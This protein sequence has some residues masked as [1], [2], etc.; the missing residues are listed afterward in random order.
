MDEEASQCP[1]SMSQ[2]TVGQTPI[3][4]RQRDVDDPLLKR[5][6]PRLQAGIGASEPIECAAAVGVAAS[7]AAGLL[8]CAV[9]GLVAFV[10]IAV[11]DQMEIAPTGSRWPDLLVVVLMPAG[12]LVGAVMATRAARRRWLDALGFSPTWSMVVGL[13]ATRVVWWRSPAPFSTAPAAV[14]G[15]LPRAEVS[16]KS[17]GSLTAR[18][19]LVL[20]DG[21]ELG[22][23]YGARDGGQTKRF[24]AN[25]AAGQRG[26]AASVPVDR[27]R[28]RSLPGGSPGSPF[29]G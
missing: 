11:I 7:S 19:V 5:L 18:M 2:W 4:G 27:R 21:D 25:L 29:S 1:S 13:T 12:Y 24:M 22:L 26:L 17:S 15:E 3:V 10:L 9:F 14:L 6:R 16:A 20:P 28:R 8:G 23:D